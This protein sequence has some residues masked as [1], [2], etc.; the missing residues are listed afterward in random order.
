MN[1]ESSSETHLI[2]SAGN[3]PEE[4]RRQ[5]VV[6]EKAKFD[7]MSTASYTDAILKKSACYA[8]TTVSSELNFPKWPK[9]SKRDFI[10]RRELGPL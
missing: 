9:W 10:T 6:S 5:P 7:N 8:R 1:L 4:V 2:I 3:K